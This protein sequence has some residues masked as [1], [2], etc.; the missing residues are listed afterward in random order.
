V[1][2]TVEV[3]QSGTTTTVETQQTRG[4]VIEETPVTAN[5]RSSAS[6]SSNDEEPTPARHR[7]TKL[8]QPPAF[9]DLHSRLDKFS[10][11]A[12]EGDFEIITWSLI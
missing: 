12:G 3:V 4:E 11:K 10:G 7:Q 6:E 9:R 2:K 5:S 1:P 8:R